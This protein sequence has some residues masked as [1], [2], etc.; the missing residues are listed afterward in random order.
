M[1]GNSSMVRMLLDEKEAGP[2]VF[3]DYILLPSDRVTCMINDFHK[4][5]GFDRTQKL[6]IEIQIHSCRLFV[7]LRS[8]TTTFFNATFE[9]I[10]TSKSA[11]PPT[12]LYRTF[13]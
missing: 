8:G 2:M 1:Y 11:S 9:A 7:I 5:L 4:I 3:F 6:M 10:F 13:P 12:K